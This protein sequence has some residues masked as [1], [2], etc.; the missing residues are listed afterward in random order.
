MEQRDCNTASQNI[1]YL[2]LAI[3]LIKNYISQQLYHS[4][5]LCLAD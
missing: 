5:K 4:V 3:P 2:Y 1:I